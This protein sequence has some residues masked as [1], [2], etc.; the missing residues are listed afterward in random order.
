MPSE[1]MVFPAPSLLDA[2]DVLPELMSW[3]Q[4]GLQTALVTLVDVDGATPRP[5]GAQMVV[6]SDGRY[7]GYLSGGCL[8]QAVALEAQRVFSNR[9]NALLKYGKG[10][11][12]FDIKL[13][14]GSGLDIYFNQS[15]TADLLAEAAALRAARQAFT[16]TTDLATGSSFLAPVTSSILPVSRRENSIFHRAHVPKV[17]VMLIGA[18]P[19]LVAIAALLNATGFEMVIASPDDVSRR[20]LAALGLD[21]QALVRADTR[22][23]SSL[24]RFT[25]A[26]VAFHEHDWEPPILAQILQSP[27]FYIGALGSR[28]AHGMRSHALTA[29]GVSAADVARVHGPVGLIPA[30]KSRATLSVG[31]VAELLSEAKRAGLV[32]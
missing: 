21:C 25:A 28:T 16:W 2:D 11:P 23:I 31:V 8:E 32:S 18:G 13:P 10:S 7:A 19:M 4:A 24:D 20:E 1:A 30:A 27:A 17:R 29:M 15:L 6:A 14:C 3:T 12:Y 9:K 22:A 5:I 26:V